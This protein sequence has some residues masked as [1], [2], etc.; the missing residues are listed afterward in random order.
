[1]T[2]DILRKPL[3]EVF[4]GEDEDP[5]VAEMLALIARMTPKV[6]AATD[7]VNGLIRAVEQSLAHAQAGVICWARIDTNCGFPFGSYV[8]E[9]LP[10]EIAELDPEDWEPHGAW[11]EV[12]LAYE[13]GGRDGGF[14]IMLIELAGWIDQEGEEHEQTLLRKPLMDCG[15]EKKLYAVHFLSELLFEI[16]RRLKGMAEAADALMSDPKFIEATANVT[17]AASA[18][19]APPAS[20]N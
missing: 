17:A 7:R 19:M 3:R 2:E 14:R 20:K 15:R 13:R 6:N 1:M 4:Q 10:P 9:P 16:A 12:W 18:A 5:S 8:M 11:T